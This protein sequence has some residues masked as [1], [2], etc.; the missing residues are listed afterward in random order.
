MVNDFARFERKWQGR[1]QRNRAEFPQETRWH[2]AGNINDPGMYN[3]LTYQNNCFQSLTIE[4]FALSVQT[5]IEISRA[6][7]ARSRLM[8]LSSA[9]RHRPALSLS[10]ATS[11]SMAVIVL[12]RSFMSDC[13]RFMRASIDANPR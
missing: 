5:S 11:I 10:S 8:F 2:P 7:L 12:L 4:H 1:P 13:I 3:R 6:R 9:P